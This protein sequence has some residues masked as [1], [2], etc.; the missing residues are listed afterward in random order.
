MSPDLLG[1]WRRTR[2]LRV[3]IAAAV[4]VAMWHFASVQF[5]NGALDLL[6]FAPPAAV[7]GLSAV[8]AAHVFVPRRFTWRRGLA[9][10]VVGALVLGPLGAFLV[11]FLAALQPASFLI[12]YS[13]GAWVALALGLVIGGVIAAVQWMTRRW[14]R[15][16]GI[17]RMRVA[18]LPRRALPRMPDAGSGIRPTPPGR[19]SQYD[20]K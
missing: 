3:V 2:L 13:V 11:A 5:A 17:R 1:V 18:R 19:Q 10:V 16:S 7:L 8:W 15:R 9:G 12:V 6:V 20:R 14:R 4:V